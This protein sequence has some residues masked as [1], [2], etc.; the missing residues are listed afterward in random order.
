MT[1]FCVYLMLFS[2]YLE[3]MTEMESVEKTIDALTLD[4]VNS[5]GFRSKVELYDACCSGDHKIEP[6]SSGE[7]ATIRTDAASTSDERIIVV[8]RHR[9]PHNYRGSSGNKRS[10]ISI[11]LNS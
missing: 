9:K 5:E 3:M 4:E 1:E 2:L 6:R 7:S 10:R 8:R 11:P